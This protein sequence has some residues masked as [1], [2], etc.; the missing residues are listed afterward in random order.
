MTGTSFP[1]SSLQIKEGKVARSLIQKG[2]PLRWDFSFRTGR[3]KLR[4]FLASGRSDSRGG[5]ARCDR[6]R[7]LLH[8]LDDD[9]RLNETQEEQ[10][11][12]KLHN[13]ASRLNSL[14]CPEFIKGSQHAI[15]GSSRTCFFVSGQR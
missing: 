3:E 2:F 14:A 5:R 1:E 12:S 15:G 8:L 9:C 11:R 6:A 7:E 4:H 10:V 13:A